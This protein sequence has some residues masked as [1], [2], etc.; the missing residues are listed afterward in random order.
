MRISDWSSDVCSSDLP[1]D[2]TLLVIR[3]VVYAE[4]RTRAFVNG[5]PVN[6]GQ[7]RELGEMLIEVFGQSESQTLLRVDVQRDALDDYGCSEATRE[8]VI[9][10]AQSCAAAGQIGSAA[11]RDRVCHDV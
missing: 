9:A 2:P 4:G 7:L 5:S 11:C 3:R 6:A 8:A 10:A 1:D